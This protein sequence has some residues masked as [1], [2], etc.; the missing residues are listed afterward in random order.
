MPLDASRV[1]A[2]ISELLSALGEDPTR[3][4]L[5]ET[6]ARVARAYKELLG[7]MD[8][9]PSQHL[10]KQ[11]FEPHNEEMVIVKD[12]VFSSMCEHHMLPFVGTAAVAYIPRDGRITGLSKISRCVKGYARRLQVQERLTAQIADAFV[13]VLNPLGVL[14]V[15]RA[16]HMCMT[17]RGVQSFGSTTLTSAV[18]GAFKTNAKTCEEAMGLL[19]LRGQS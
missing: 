10:R 11:F 7:G 6:P 4:A 15:L 9:D 1:E 3:E 18:R 8:E 5:R 17:I 16:E 14:V 12:I 19:G 13:D 2:A